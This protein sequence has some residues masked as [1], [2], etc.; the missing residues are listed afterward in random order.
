MR[1]LLRKFQNQ[2]L[3]LL[4]IVDAFELDLGAAQVT[5]SKKT[6]EKSDATIEEI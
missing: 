2:I 1:F 4:L 5:D 3:K 6:D